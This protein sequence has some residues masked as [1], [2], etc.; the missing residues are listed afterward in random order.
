MINT[1]EHFNLFNIF[2]L[3][4]AFPLEFLH[5]VHYLTGLNMFSFSYFSNGTRS[6]IREANE[7]K[8]PS[9]AQCKPPL[10]DRLVLDLSS[11]F[12]ALFHWS[13]VR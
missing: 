11:G 9:L 5:W 10:L 12:A 7:R 6:V 3:L 13:C 4:S 1:N 2:E 8:A